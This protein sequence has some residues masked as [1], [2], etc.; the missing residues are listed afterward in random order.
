MGTATIPFSN[1]AGNNQ[2]SPA[3]KAGPTAVS[4]AGAIPGAPGAP[5]AAN[6]YVAP[7]STALPTTTVLGGGDVTGGALAGQLTDI[8]GSGV[9][10]AINSE[11]SNIGGVNSATI[12]DFTASLQPGMAVQQANLNAGLG[13]GGVGA[14]SSVA[15][16]ADASLQAQEGAAIS[17]ETASLLQ[18]QE[19]LTANILGGTEGAAVS[20]T[21]SSGW[22]TFGQIMN[23]AG[24]DAV[25]IAKLASL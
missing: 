22:D 6:P 25:G 10:G 20:E 2:T 19:A 17:G 15:A 13:A 14:N 16:I 21:A 3:S 7:T 12:A 23:A 5:T 18:S 4:S 1:P 9:G 24:T 8:Y 11:L